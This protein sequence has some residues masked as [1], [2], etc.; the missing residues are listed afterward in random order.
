MKRLLIILAMC[1]ASSSVA[2]KCDTI[3]DG[4]IFKSYFS[5]EVKQPIAVTY[6]LYQGGGE[7]SRYGMN[8]IN[9]TKISMLGGKDYAGKGYD[10]GHMANAEDF[11]YDLVKEEQTFRYYNCVPQTPEMNR[12]PWKKYETKARK[13]SQLQHIKIVCYNVFGKEKNP[14]FGVRIPIACYKAVYD[15]DTKKL[16]FAIGIE[17][18]SDP[19][20]IKVT[21]QIQAILNKY[22]K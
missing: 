20:E 18:D 12:G 2:Q 8:F 14:Q 10:K 7:M 1:L 4:K 16:L 22:F 6:T 11:A 17:N 13:L 21:P 9:D 3:I 19:M 5:Y 15:M